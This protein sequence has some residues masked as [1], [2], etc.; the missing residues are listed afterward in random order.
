M[1]IFTEAKVLSSTEQVAHQNIPNS[2]GICFRH[3]SFKKNPPLVRAVVKK[4]ASPAS[5]EILQSS[6]CPS[7]TDNHYFF[8][9]SLALSQEVSILRAVSHA[10]NPAAMAARALSSGWTQATSHRSPV[11]NISPPFFSRDHL[12]LAPG[13]SGGL[14]PLC[15]PPASRREKQ[16]D[17]GKQKHGGIPWWQASFTF[18]HYKLCT[19]TFV[20]HRWD[21]F[22][23]VP[24]PHLLSGLLLSS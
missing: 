10:R 3:H 20:F 12:V 18:I 11:A 14:F 1:D 19:Y 5:S 6:F 4:K 2:A 21:S 13:N 23:K 15:Q 7:H 8:L 24:F 9:S 22:S 17:A 16:D